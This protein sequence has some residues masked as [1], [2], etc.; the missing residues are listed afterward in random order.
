VAKWS[1]ISATAAHSFVF[2]LCCTFFLIGECV[3]VVLGL[4]FPYQA[5]RSAW[6]NISVITYL[7]SS[8]T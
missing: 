8:G 2:I 5:K 1:L 4:V 6:G 7:V 3:F